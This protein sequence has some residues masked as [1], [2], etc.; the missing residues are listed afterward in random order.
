[1]LR[2]LLFGSIIGLSA[3][4][5]NVGCCP[6]GS[7]CNTDSETPSATSTDATGESAP[8][9]E[10]TEEGAEEFNEEIDVENADSPEGVV[11]A[12]FKAFFS[13]DRAAAFALL[14]TKAREAQRE[15]F[16]AESSSTIQWQVASKKRGVGGR[17]YVTVDVED[18]AENG[19]IKTDSLTFVMTRD[20]GA[21]RVAGF[22][23]GEIAVNFED[24]V[25]TRNDKNREPVRVA[26]ELDGAVI[27]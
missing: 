6:C 26:R 3:F 27:R 5:V 20:A 21:W 23:V 19:D 2:Y 24:S 18:Y 11:D 17:V 7:D 10:T 12:F 4:I 22:N 8:N 9:S 25:M 16:A 13:G 1:M 15:Q 14:S